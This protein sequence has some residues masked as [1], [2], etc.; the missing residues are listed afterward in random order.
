MEQLQAGA[1]RI[2]QLTATINELRQEL[3]D[4]TGRKEIMQRKETEAK[5]RRNH[6]DQMMQRVQ[7]VA[8]PTLPSNN[9]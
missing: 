9:K 6:C 3:D 7:D 2:E 8:L 5:A 4:L 1:K